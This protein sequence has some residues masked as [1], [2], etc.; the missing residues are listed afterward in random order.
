MQVLK[1]KWVCS[2]VLARAKSNRKFPE[3]GGGNHY[4]CC[5]CEGCTECDSES[6]DEVDDYS[7]EAIIQAKAPSP[8]L[9][10]Q[11]RPASTPAII[12]NGF[13]SAT[14]DS[15][16]LSSEAASREVRTM[17][18][19]ELINK[20]RHDI[21]EARNDRISAD[22]SLRLILADHKQKIDQLMGVV[23][24]CQENLKGLIQFVNQSN[25]AHERALYS[26]RNPI[27]SSRAGSQLGE[28]VQPGSGVSCHIIRRVWI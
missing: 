19:M 16:D 26:L 8:T 9:L 2:S 28:R 27:Q 23:T 17:R 1:L 12:Q 3:G 10:L 5:E 15:L 14:G 20:L 6:N 4:N 11:P 24:E 7:V 13:S 25:A 21:E 18:A 22:S